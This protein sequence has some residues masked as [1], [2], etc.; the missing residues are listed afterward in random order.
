MTVIEKLLLLFAASLLS[1][2][3]VLSFTHPDY[4]ATGLTVEDGPVEWFTVF[5]LLCS[6]VLCASRVVKLAGKR[7]G[8]FIMTYCILSL[9][10]FFGAGEEISWGQRIFGIE[11]GE[12]FAQNNAQRETN[13]HNLV[14][15]E[16]KINK[17]IFGTGIS[18]VLFTYVVIL[19]P[20]YTRNQPVRRFLI[21]FGVPIPK[22][23]HIVAYIVLLS[24]V[25]LIMTASRRGEMI[26]VVGSIIVFMNL[27]FPSNSEIFDPEKPLEELV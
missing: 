1:L 12:F 17:L 4:F 3:A 8:L 20:M 2:G 16:T 24:V 22:S 14:V 23:Y 26:E 7:N 10:F 19:T 25:Q 18:L 21:H 11:S 15:G 6:L 27:A 9:F 13:L 5:M